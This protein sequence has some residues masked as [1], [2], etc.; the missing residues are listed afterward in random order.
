MRILYVINYYKPAYVYGGP[1]QSISTMCEALVQQGAHVTVLTS[2]VNG[3]QRLAV[4][5]RQ[6]VNVDGVEVYY[7]PIVPLPP[8]SFFYSPELARAAAAQVG[9]FDITI[10]DALWTHAL[11]PAA[12]ACSKARVPYIVPLRGQILPRAIQR[13]SLRKWCYLALGG[14][15]CLDAAAALYCTDASEAEA[16]ARLRLRAPPFVIPNGIHTARWERLPPRGALR[17]R[18]GVPSD[19][20][21]ILFLGRL[22]SIKRPD[23]ALDGLITSGLPQTHL[24]YVG[25]DEGGYASGL[26]ARAEQQGYAKRI[27]FTGLL[28]DNELSQA[29]ADVDLLLM[30]SETE[31]FG[32]AAAE[33][34]AAGVPVLTS[35]VVPVGQQAAAAGAGRAVP[36]AV[37]AFAQ[38]LRELLADPVA[39]RAMGQRGQKLAR[40]CF[41][42]RVVASQMLKQLQA[43]ISNGRPLHEAA[44]SQ[45]P[46]YKL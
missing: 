5:L 39:L 4:P 25:P 9:Q 10:V 6:S 21:L 29:M 45:Q 26:R 13:R 35:D 42:T 46:V 31:S 19:A 20:A 18:L 32:M 14:R 12:V 15:A 43:I 1:V 23:I 22:H 11:R 27:H 37:P 28:Y 2:D 41:D 40:Q 3:T 24:V 38:A 33:A 44:H 17:Q 30:P 36:I 8:R 16:A 34:L 7:Y